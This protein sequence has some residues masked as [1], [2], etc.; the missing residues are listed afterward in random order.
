MR[1]KILTVMAALMSAIFA[2]AQLPTQAPS[3]PTQ[4]VSSGTLDFYPDFKSQYITSRNV[5][6]WLPDGYTLGE[7]CD[8]LYMHDGQMLFDATTTW[9]KQE[10]KVDEVM[11]R[12]IAEGKV[13]RCIVVTQRLLPHPML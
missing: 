7:P 5:T 6:V 13:R 10:W 8:V 1:T 12:L 9:N 11:G 2:M 4:Q 3:Q